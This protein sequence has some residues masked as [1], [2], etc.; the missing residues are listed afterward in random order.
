M[1]LI[2]IVLMLAINAIFAAYEMA[3]ASISKT[4]ISVLLQEGRNGAKQALF[5]KE[6]I[7]GSLAVI[8]IAVSL[9]GAIAAATGGAKADDIVAPLFE[10]YL[11]LHTHIANLLAF[12]C[13]VIPISFITIE[14]GELIPKGYALRNKDTVLLTLSPLMKMLYQLLLPIVNI[15]EK[16]VRL[17][18][19][20]K[21]TLADSKEAK[22]EAMEDLRTAT[23]IAS[24]SRLF[25]KTEEKIVLSSAQFCTRKIKEIQVPLEQVYLL[26]ADD[27]IADTLV[28]A[29]LDM[30]TRFPVCENNDPQ[31]IIGYLNFKDIFSSTKN[32]SGLP[33][34]A[35]RIVRP[36]LKLNEDLIISSALQQ[37]MKT[38]QHICLVTNYTG[39]ITGILTLED[40]F[41]EMVGDIEDEYDTAPAYIKPFGEGYL[42]SATAKMTDVF[43]QLAIETPTDIDKEMNVE[44]WITKQLQHTPTK[45]ERILAQ[46]LFLE[47]RKFRRHKLVEAFVKKD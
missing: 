18:T 29:H 37:L 14:F 5:M 9:A 25:S 11:H 12:S 27:S 39:N 26:N 28:K 31:Q 45:N 21:N 16:L 24:V 40:I 2:I 17:V 41:E 4:R 43:K 10:K 23:T 47:T 19:H 33:N 32:A 22:Q 1:T 30:H 36:I 34:T 6:H 20:K 3:L 35:R 38:Q 8:Q 7:E 42:V 13:I 15:M 46:G 44:Q